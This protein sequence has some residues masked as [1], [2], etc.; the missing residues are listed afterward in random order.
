MH[1]RLRKKRQEMVKRNG[2]VRW[3]SSATRIFKSDYLNKKYFIGQHL[4]WVN[5]MYIH[6]YDW[7]NDKPTDDFFLLL[8]SERI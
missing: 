2:Y 5:N 7:E 4:I 8:A 6:T 1:P 3:G